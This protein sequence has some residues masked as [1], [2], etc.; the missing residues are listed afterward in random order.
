ML[1]IND[2]FTIFCV[3]SSKSFL[4]S[5]IVSPSPPSISGSTGVGGSSTL[6]PSISFLV[7]A[8]AVAEVVAVVVIVDEIS[9]PSFASSSISFRSPT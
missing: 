3:S 4:G 5:S 2:C 9:C 7:F 1:I 6:S 8:V